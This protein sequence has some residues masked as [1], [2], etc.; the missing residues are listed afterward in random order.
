MN[1]KD[2]IQA[3]CADLGDDYP[4]I[5]Q[6]LNAPTTIDNPVAEAPQVAHPPTLDDVLAVVPSA[7]RVAIR[8]LAG[9][10]DDVR[11]A[12]DTQNLLYMQ[13]LIE[14]ALT[15]NAISAQTATALAMLLQRTQ[16]DP[17][18]AAQIAGPSLAQAAGV[19][20][21]TA[22]Q[23]QAVLNAKWLSRWRHRPGGNQAAQRARCV[24]A[25]R[26]DGRGNAHHCGIY[27]E[28][29]HCGGLGR[30]LQRYLYR[31]RRAHA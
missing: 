21:V 9:F 29:R 10:V 20:T 14:D 22:A 28:R 25:S 8:A 17:A 11:R 12:I 24:M 1:L 7:E 5:A 2:L 27:C 19:G 30:W 6:R 3:H 23:V 16:A 18:W 4:A 31:Q 26:H 15:A 13:T